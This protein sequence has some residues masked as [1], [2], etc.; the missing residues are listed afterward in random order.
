MDQAIRVLE[1]VAKHTPDVKITWEDHDFGGCSIDKHG[2]PLP[3]STLKACQAADAILMGTIPIV[4]SDSTLTKL[5]APL[6]AQNGAWMPK[7][8]QNKVF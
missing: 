8:G 4:H 1:V 7:S 3:E 5:K 2:E 6:V